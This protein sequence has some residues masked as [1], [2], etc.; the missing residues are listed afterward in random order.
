VFAYRFSFANVINGNILKNSFKGYPA[1]REH[2]AE[3]VN[4][5]GN[6]LKIWAIKLPSSLFRL[7]QGKISQYIGIAG[8]R[9]LFRQKTAENLKYSAVQY[10]N[11]IIVMCARLIEN[12]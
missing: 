4:G 11:V 5:S 1:I 3:I 12:I 10:M 6:I 8:I 7:A 9:C 2:M